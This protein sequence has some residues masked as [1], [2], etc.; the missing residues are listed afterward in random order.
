[1][2]GLEVVDARLVDPDRLLGLL[3]AISTDPHFHPH[4]FGADFVGWLRGYTGR[5]RYRVGRLADGRLVAYGLL[6]GWD[7][8]FAVPSLGIAVHPAARGAGVAS[9]MMQALHDEALAAGARAVRLRV[10][11]ENHPAIGL[12]RKFGYAAAGQERGQM[13]MVVTLPSEDTPWTR[14]DHS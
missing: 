11:S 14:S 1:M 3:R 9:R 7:L 10:H 6:R 4:S 8:G 12:Y 13:V 2:H 5:D